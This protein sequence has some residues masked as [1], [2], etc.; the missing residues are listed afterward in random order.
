MLHSRTL[1][2]ST[3][4]FAIAIAAYACWSAM[5]WSKAAYL[6]GL[7]TFGSLSALSCFWSCDRIP[8]SWR[9]SV[10]FI[11]V[12][13][14]IYALSVGPALRHVAIVNR[15]PVHDVELKTNFVKVYHPILECVLAS[16]SS[17]SPKSVA[18][19]RWWM[20]SDIQL[21]FE[22][23]HGIIGRYIGAN[24]AVSS[25]YLYWSHRRSDG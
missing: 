15:P 14:L 8:T 9:W 25:K 20:P 23:G 12:L 2:L 6:T 18:F 22:D 19:L 4:F 13:H 10:R 16:P 21:Q 17:S 11:F 5:N 3:A 7:L 24:G 1:R